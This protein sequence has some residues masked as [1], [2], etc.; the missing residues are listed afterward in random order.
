MLNFRM[1]IDDK[2]TEDNE[3]PAELSGG[4]LQDEHKR[5]YQTQCN[6]SLADN[7]DEC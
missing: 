2:C 4:I 1:V 7:T 6:D 3:E 5:T